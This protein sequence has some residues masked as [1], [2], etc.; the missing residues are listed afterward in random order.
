MAG[1]ELRCGWLDN[2]SSPNWQLIDEDRAWPIME[3]A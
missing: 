2:Q 1:S 3:F